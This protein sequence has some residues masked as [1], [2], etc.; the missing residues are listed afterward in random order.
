[1]KDP[2]DSL[3]SIVLL[4]FFFIGLVWIMSLGF[5]AN[6]QRWVPPSDFNQTIHAE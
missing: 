4:A 3:F 6:G 2:L 5:I 1:M